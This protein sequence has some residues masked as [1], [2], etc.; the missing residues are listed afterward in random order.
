MAFAACL[1]AISYSR[2]I[3]PVDDAMTGEDA[4]NPPMP[5]PHFAVATIATIRRCVPEGPSLDERKS[6]GDGRRGC[7]LGRCGDCAGRAV[8]AKPADHVTAALFRA[9]RHLGRLRLHNRAGRSRDARA[10]ADRVCAAAAAAGCS[11]LAAAAARVAHLAATG[12][13]L[14]AAAVDEVEL[15]LDVAEAL[16]NWGLCAA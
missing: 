16:W 10:Q 2:L 6:H 9:R 4:V 12:R 8:A 3:I 5:P 1:E 14:P 15:Q 11:L 13:Y 7:I